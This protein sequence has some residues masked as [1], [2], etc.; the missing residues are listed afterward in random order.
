MS[1]TLVLEPEAAAE[2]QE[3]AD[4]YD[5][6]SQSV[7]IRFLNAV[8]RTLAFIQEHPEQYQIVYHH[9][10]RAVLRPFPYALMYTAS[11]DTVTIIA[12][13]N[14]RRDPKRW[15]DRMR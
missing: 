3:A 1:R 10:R 5:A 2:I 4:W 11:D 8:E 7:R 6:T 12:C 13:L 9:T 15:E 14:T